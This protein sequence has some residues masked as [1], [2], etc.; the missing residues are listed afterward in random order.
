M[1]AGGLFYCLYREPLDVA[2]DPRQVCGDAAARAGAQVCAAHAVQRRIRRVQSW[3]HLAEAGWT[4]VDRVGERRGVT[5]ASRM[6]ASGLRHDD[7]GV[8]RC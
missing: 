5:K 2:L 4:S 7:A 3:G 6:S 1:F 8:T